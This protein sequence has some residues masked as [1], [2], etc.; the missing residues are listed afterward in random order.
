MLTEYNIKRHYDSK[1]AESVYGKLKGRKQELK[2]D[3][4]KQLAQ[5]CAYCYLACY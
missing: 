5:C 2:V 1:H 4:F 3:L